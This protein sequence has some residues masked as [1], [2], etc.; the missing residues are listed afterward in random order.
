MTRETKI[1]LLVGLAFIIV[2]GILL[3][4]YN[5]IENQQAPLYGAT[6]DVRQS[7]ATPATNDNRNDLTVVA[8]PPTQ[9]S[10]RQIVPM[11]E[12]VN[13]SR[14]D[15][16][17][18]VVTIRP[19][20]GNPTL[21]VP[22]HSATTEPA[23]D[24]PPVVLNPDSGAADAEPSDVHSV[25]RDLRQTAADHHEQIVAVGPHGDARSSS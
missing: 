6:K 4:D 21:P 9:V 17:S 11:R 3:S 22:T 12:E 18:A 15:H 2:I 1:G 8:P 7:T 25:P 20:T 5:R 14:D 23:D 16:S 19:G 13:G 10:P 24:N